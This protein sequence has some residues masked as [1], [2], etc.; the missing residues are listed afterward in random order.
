MN[1]QVLLAELPQGPLTEAHFEIRTVDIPTPGPG[2]VVV[3]SILLSIDAANRAWMQGATYRSAIESGQVMAGYA[4]GEVVDTGGDSSLRPG[5]LVLGDLGWQEY[6]V[7]KARRLQPVPADHR[8]LTDYH[9]IL[10]IAGLTA[11]HGLITLFG[12][13]EGDTLLV[14]A[15]AG[16]VGSL[17][18]QIGKIHGATVVGIAGGPDKCDW[19]VNTLGFD[20]CI[21]YKNEKVS[22]ALRDH[23]PNGVDI[24]FDNVG[25]SILEAAL[26]VMN[27]H[28]KISCCGAISQYEAT[29]P[30]GTRGVPGLI[31][32]KRL[33]MKG[34]I[35]LDYPDLD[36]T[37][38]LALAG[39]AAEGK[40]TAPIDVMDGITSAPAALIGLL[41]GNNRGKRMVRVG[42]D[43]A[44]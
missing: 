41:A 16:S 33:T 32:T 1:T 7:V 29:S 13:D 15:A 14:S 21:D 27:L 3:R 37:A 44:F 31:V 36:P 17:V 42:A 22:T 8:P 18:G 39:W 40:L 43:P 10:G 12:V 38:R 19:V 6:A 5:D 11:Y 25:G 24:Y 23:C 30:V 9:T 26:G 28:G 2:E 4:L 34:F 20:S 35:A